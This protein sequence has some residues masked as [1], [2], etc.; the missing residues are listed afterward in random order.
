MRSLLGFLVLTLIMATGCTA[1]E[2][3]P[4]V[5]DATPAVVTDVQP[6]ATRVATNGTTPIV[7]TL[8]HEL[9]AVEPTEVAEAPLQPVTIEATGEP[10]L[11][12]G[13]PWATIAADPNDDPRLE[14]VA[15]RVPSHAGRTPLALQFVAERP[16]RPHEHTHNGNG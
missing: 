6:A 1:N 3:A 12:G 13:P 7:R 8:L 14:T 10:W 11:A 2:P 5:G 4:T 16:D 9:P 15:E